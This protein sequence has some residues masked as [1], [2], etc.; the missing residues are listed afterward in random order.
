[1]AATLIHYGDFFVQTQDYTAKRTD[2]LNKFHGTF[3][4]FS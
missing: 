2:Q 1:M 3:P 4:N